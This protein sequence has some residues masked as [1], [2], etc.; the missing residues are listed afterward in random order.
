MEALNGIDR[1]TSL[2][3]VRDTELAKMPEGLVQ[4]IRVN[5]SNFVHASVLC[6]M[7]QKCKTQ[8]KIRA[9]VFT[10]ILS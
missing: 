9:K 7:E 6:Y 1:S 5:I 10:I 4:H 2:H 8:M 3:A